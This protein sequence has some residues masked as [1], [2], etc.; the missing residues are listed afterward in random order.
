MAHKIRSRHDLKEDSFVT[1]VLKAKEY[2]YEHQNAFFIGLETLE[3]ML[4]Q[5]KE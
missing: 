3:T 1:A 4:E 2:I 5:G